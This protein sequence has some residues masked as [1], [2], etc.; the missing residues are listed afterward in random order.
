M[1]IR[2]YNNHKFKY[3]IWSKQEIKMVEIKCINK[4]K[5]L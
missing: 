3:K 4:A 2:N 5:Q 1:F